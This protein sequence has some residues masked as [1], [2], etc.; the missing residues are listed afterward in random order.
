MKCMDVC[1]GGW[2]HACMHLCMIVCVYVCMYVC[3]RESDDP[4]GLYTQRVASRTALR[5]PIP[6][7]QGAG[8]PY[9]PL[10]PGAPGPR[11]QAP[12]P[13]RQT[14]SPKNPGPRAQGACYRHPAAQYPAQGTWNSYSA[15]QDTAYR[16]GW[17]PT[18][19]QPSPDR[20]VSTQRP[21]SP[22]G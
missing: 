19:P 14:S 3:T 2:M 6:R 8:R 22:H 15:T 5:A 4:T 13:R 16:S 9:G 10:Y 11:S 7:C 21:V 1:M 12:C 18:V 20:S 17:R